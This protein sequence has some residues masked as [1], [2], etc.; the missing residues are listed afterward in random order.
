MNC[1]VCWNSGS[2]PKALAVT[3]QGAIE[4]VLRDRSQPS[5]IQWSLGNEM[6]VDQNL[7]VAYRLFMKDLDASRPYATD[8]YLTEDSGHN[9]MPIDNLHYTP[10]A[11]VA[12]WIALRRSR[13]SRASGGI[14]PATTARRSTP[15]PACATSGPTASPTSGTKWYAIHGLPGRLD[16][17]RHRR[18]LSDARRHIHRLGR[19]RHDRHLAA[20]QTRVLALQEDL[21]AAAHQG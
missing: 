19:V 11:K 6:S 8:G 18:Y 17:V 14:R 12:A 20:S 1:P 2:G 21:L 10:T 7:L 9:G 4:M 3:L 15:I 16:L 5:V 13:S